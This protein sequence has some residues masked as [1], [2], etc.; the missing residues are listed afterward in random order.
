MSESSQRMRLDK[1]LW[2]ARFFKTRTL[3]AEAVKGGKVHVN[4]Q[5]VKPSKE[6]GVGSRIEITK[7]PYTWEITVVALETR[8][9]PAKEAVLLYEETPESHARRQE[10]VARRRAQREAAGHPQRRPD[11]KQ[12]RLIHRF[13][14]GAD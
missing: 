10:E 3:A 13:K 6:I 8:R 12:R 11:K 5:R 4:G 9:R 14:R 7:E 1:W 2:A